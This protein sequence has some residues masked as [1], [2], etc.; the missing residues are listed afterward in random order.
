MAVVPY[1]E[2]WLD[3]WVHVSSYQHVSYHSCISLGLLG[4]LCME[5]LK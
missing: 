2:D 5:C 4:V 3:G 1:T